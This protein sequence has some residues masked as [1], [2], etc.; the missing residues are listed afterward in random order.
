MGEGRPSKPGEAIA[1]KMSHQAK[2]KRGRDGRDIERLLLE[3]PGKGNTPHTFVHTHTYVSH[4]HTM[5]L[6]FTANKRNWVLP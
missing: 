5:K 3:R 6:A 1:A 4:S 2:R